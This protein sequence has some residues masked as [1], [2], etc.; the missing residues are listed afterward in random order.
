MWICE[1]V[2]MNRENFTFSTS[3]ENGGSKFMKI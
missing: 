1:S 2:S 3:I